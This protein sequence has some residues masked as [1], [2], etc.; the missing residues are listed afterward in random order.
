MDNSFEINDVR[1]F[2][3]EQFVK[4]QIQDDHIVL[5]YLYDNQ[6]RSKIIQGNEVLEGKNIA[7]LN[8]QTSVATNEPDGFSA[9]KLEYWYQ[10]SFL[11]A[12][13][14]RSPFR[15]GGRAKVFY[16]NKITFQQ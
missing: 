2:T 10:S 7:P 15:Q 4:L 8:G 9:N 13:C 3:L 1:T 6:L 5:L 14:R 11:P 16:V 12:V